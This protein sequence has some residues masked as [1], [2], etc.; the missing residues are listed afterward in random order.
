MADIQLLQSLQT[1][2]YVAAAAGTVVIYD[3]VLAF[4]QELDFIWNRNW[5]LMTVLYLIA[6]H[7]GSVC[8]IGNAIWCTF[9]ND[10]TYSANLNMYLAVSWAQTIFLQAMR[11]ILVIR[12][13]ALLNR[14]K[15]AAAFL[16]TFYCLQATAAFAMAVLLTTP[17]VLHE[18]LV[19]ID[20]AV[21]TVVA[22][23]DTRFPAIT[24]E[25]L[26]LNITTVTVVFDTVLLFFALLAFG[27]H[28]LGAKRWDG[29]WSINML[30]KTLVADH[31]M[32]FLCYLV[33]M[34]LTLVI[35]YNTEALTMTLV[36]RLYNISR[37][38]AV[39]AGPRMVISIREI[40]NTT[41]RGGTMGGELSTIRFDIPELVTQSESAIEEGGGI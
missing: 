35:D 40:E 9:T 11:A 25:S 4:S 29:G 39:V 41:M 3:Q 2:N 16:A 24:A 14:S 34:S 21:G 28:S 6:H 18:S 37:A 20:P 30:V 12:V 15:K 26:P 33:W 10:W 38:L 1:G 27:R 32:Y 13:Y 5:S 17:Q 22:H 7:S 19:S 23:I 36:N 31:L 8:T